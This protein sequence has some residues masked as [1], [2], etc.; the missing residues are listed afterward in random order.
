MTDKLIKYLDSMP[1]KN[2]IIDG[3]FLNPKSVTVFLKNFTEPLYLFYLDSPKDE[4]YMNIS[5][6]Y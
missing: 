6:Y 5:K 1:S 2:A 3:F 4:I